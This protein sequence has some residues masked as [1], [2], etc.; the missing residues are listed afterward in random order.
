MDARRSTIFKE[1]E[2]PFRDDIKAIFINPPTKATIQS[3]NPV[4]LTLLLAY[5]VW[6]AEHL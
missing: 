4:I 5:V 3:R 6:H 1:Q 2:V